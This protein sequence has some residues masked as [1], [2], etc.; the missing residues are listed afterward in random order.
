[1]SVEAGG[2]SGGDDLRPEAVEKQ[3]EDHG[4]EDGTEAHV[5]SNPSMKEE[6]RSTKSEV[7]K[8]NYDLRIVIAG[9]STAERKT[10]N[11]LWPRT[12]EMCWMSYREMVVLDC[13]LFGG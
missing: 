4:R 1:M 13:S 10:A 7:G 8:L 9:A 5:L 2:E 6:G 11:L 3:G 12:K